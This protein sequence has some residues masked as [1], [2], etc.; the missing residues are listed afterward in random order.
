MSIN[1]QICD[2][3]GGGGGSRV[4]TLF[5]AK[6]LLDTVYCFV[7]VESIEYGADLSEQHMKKTGHQSAV[8]G[9][10]GGGSPAW[11]GSSSSSSSTVARQNDRWCVAESL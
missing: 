7:D 11:A 3:C 8:S 1:G 10:G 5:V 9:G 2:S 4:H 6:T